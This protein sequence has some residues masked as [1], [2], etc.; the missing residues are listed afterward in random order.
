MFSLLAASLTSSF[1]QPIWGSVAGFTAMVIG[2]IFQGLLVAFV[3]G[4]GFV[5]A[6][7]SVMF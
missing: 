4:L 2:I 1:N 7:L 6:L 5:V 3:V